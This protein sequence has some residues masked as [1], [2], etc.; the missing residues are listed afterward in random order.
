VCAHP[1]GRFCH[2]WAFR[3]VLER[4]YQYECFAWEIVLGGERVGVF[5]AI[6][7]RRGGN[8]LVSMPFQEYGGPLLLDAAVTHAAEVAQQLVATTA[9]AGLR[10][11]ELRGP[12][13]AAALQGTPNAVLHPLY[14][15]AIV[16]LAEK[17]VMFKKTLRQE[18]RKG[19]NRSVEQGLT[20][21]IRI[22]ANALAKSFEPMYLDSVKRLGVPPHSLRFLPEMAAQFGEQFV[23]SWVRYREQDIAVL[24]GIISNQRIHAYITA[25]DPNFWQ[26]RPNDLAHWEM[27]NWAYANGIKLFDF[28]SARYEGQIHYKK[29][30]GSK[31][32]DYGYMLLAA[33]GS[34]LLREIKTVKTDSGAMKLASDIWTRLV[35]IP[36]T[37]VLGPPLRKYLTK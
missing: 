22:G 31:F 25:S 10:S 28:G 29:K 3:D 7:V 12:V 5:P 15:Y 35:P 24:L 16:E 30:W 33:Q 2:L 20:A 17:E 34:P 4:V 37:K 21:E 11:V 1:E 27:M 18:A 26:L 6:A 23:A 32:F 14:S 8:R 13:G 9:A 36:L 19:I